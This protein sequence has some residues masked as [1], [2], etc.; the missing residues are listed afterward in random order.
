M[1]ALKKDTSLTPVQK[2]EKLKEISSE[3]DAKISPILDPAQ[4]QK[5][6]AIREENRRKLIEEMGSKAMQKL[7][8]DIKQELRNLGKKEWLSRPNPVSGLGLCTCDPQR[9]GLDD[10]KQVRDTGLVRLATSVAVIMI[11][12]SMKSTSKLRRYVTAGAVTAACLSAMLLTS[13]QKAEQEKGSPRR[14]PTFAAWSR[15]CTV[16]PS[17]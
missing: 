8:S 5:F 1:A 15:G 9:T 17:C 6:K 12:G 3:V 16:I 13:C 14:S 4:Q 10:R 7:E 2:I 11:G